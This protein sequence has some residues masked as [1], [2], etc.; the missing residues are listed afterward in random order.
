MSRTFAPSSPMRTPPIR[1]RNSSNV[2]ANM[3][4]SIPQRVNT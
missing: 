4:G 2:I 1:K 3:L